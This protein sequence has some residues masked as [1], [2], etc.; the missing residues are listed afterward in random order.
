MKRNQHFQNHMPE[1]SLEFRLA[2]KQ[3]FGVDWVEAMN[4]CKEK[5]KEIQRSYEQDLI[6]YG[7]GWN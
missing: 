2:F 7:I 5:Q 4:D 1:I 6:K 3:E